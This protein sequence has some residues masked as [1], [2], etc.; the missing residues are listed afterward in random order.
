[1]LAEECVCA[2]VSQKRLRDGEE[3]GMGQE[4]TDKVCTGT[5]EEEEGGRK[6]IKSSPVVGHL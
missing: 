3:N 4:L 1:V 5:G 6:R 2:L